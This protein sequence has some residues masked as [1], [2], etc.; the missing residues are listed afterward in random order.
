MTSLIHLV[1]GLKVQS[2]ISGIG[3]AL[4]LRNGE[5]ARI[6]L[7]KMNPF[8]TS[9][10]KRKPRSSPELFLEKNVYKIR[11]MMPARLKPDSI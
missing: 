1:L 9:L 4:T 10:S 2:C 7:W 3:L 6:S 5:L 8:R 11:G